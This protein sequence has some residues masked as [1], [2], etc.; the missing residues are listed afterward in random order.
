MHQH[1][2]M[3]QQQ[4]NQQQQAMYETFIQQQQVLF[5]SLLQQQQQ[6]TA[7][8]FAVIQ[9]LLRQLEPTNPSHAQLQQQHQV[10]QQSPRIEYDW[11]VFHDA[12]VE[13]TQMHGKQRRID[14][15][16]TVGLEVAAFHSK[17][18]KDRMTELLDLHKTK[19]KALV[20]RGQTSAKG[21]RWICGGA[22]DEKQRCEFSANFRVR[23]DTFV[24]RFGC[25]CACVLLLACLLACYVALVFSAL[26][27]L[28][29]YNGSC[30][31]ELHSAS[32]LHTAGSSPQ[33]PCKTT[34]CIP[35]GSWH[36]LCVRVC[37]AAGC[38][39]DGA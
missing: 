30:L 1:M 14:S 7:H 34:G 19:L 28:R 20:K 25:F 32:Q 12:E 29:S 27:S 21:E 8:G 39:S 15:Y 9:Q 18:A 5:Q 24:V 13:V 11:A 35:Q 3:Q 22:D 17:S 6:H 38:Q 23:K 33:S 37:C 16:L 4:Q 2:L 10:H 31:A 26:F 36:H